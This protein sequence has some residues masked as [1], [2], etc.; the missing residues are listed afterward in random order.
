MGSYPLLESITSP[1]E[2]RTLSMSQIQE[3]CSQLRQRIIDVMAV[4]GGHLSSNL[5]A[6]EITVALHHTFNSP[7]DKFLFDTSHQTYP[8]KLLT[9]RNDRFDQIRQFQGLCGFANPKESPHDHF[10]AGHAGTALSLALGMAKN[11]DLAQRNE[12]V[13]PVLGDAALTCGLTL[14][15]LNNIPS[16]LENFI[17]ILNDNAMA[18][19]KN[20][21][22]VTDIL[23]RLMNNPTTRGIEREI[24]HA[25]ANILPGECGRELVR[26]GKKVATSM[27]GLVSPAAFFAQF[28]VSYFGPFDG[29]DVKKLISVFQDVKA[30]RFG[31]II[32]HLLTNKGQGMDLAVQN[33]TCYHGPKGFDPATGKLKKG[34]PNQMTFPK[35]FGDQILRM[36]QADPSL[37]AVTPAMSAGSCLDPFR[38]QFPERCL[39]VG[40]AE[41]HCVTYCGGMAYGGKMKVV[42]S[43]YATFFQRALDNL[44]HDV[45]LQEL[46]VVFCLDR[47]GIAGGDGHTHNGIYD[48][49]FLFAMPNMVICQ[50]RD[51]HQLREL[52][53]SSF[54]WGKPTAIRYPNLTT[55]DSDRP[56]VQRE[57][58][59][60]EVLAH[61]KEFLILAL[62]HKCETALQVHERILAETGIAMTVVDPVFVKPLDVDLLHRLLL[63]HDKV[64]TLEE[65][66][67]EGGF[68]MIVNDFIITQGY[69]Q[70]QVL[71]LGIPP[72]FVAQGSHGELTKSLGLDSESVANQICNHFSLSREA[73][74]Q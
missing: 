12:F 41:G 73:I 7:K 53:D 36:A 46:P 9:G 19:S 32:L 44:F 22:A 26:K 59:R 54:R 8:H 31:P 51:G 25:L 72:E 58:G 1:A 67:L 29:H 16:S 57:V 65:H 64:I 45:C 68:G 27:K 13:I 21:G 40:I 60:G 20:V 30:K 63:T 3:L 69:R 6:V 48:L 4:K 11:R 39:D 24:G 5:G 52:L 74:V 61:G 17:I 42:C 56:L 23:S 70:T 62:G 2:I 18:I 10:Y 37:V 66:S 49:S 47:S 55:S 14:E 71:N 38:E 35:I 50:P 28:G 34:D 43:I 33:P 15:A